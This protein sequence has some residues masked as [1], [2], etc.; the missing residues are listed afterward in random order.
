M[1][2]RYSPAWS[3]IIHK[4]MYYI[5]FLWSKW[6]L[7]KLQTHIFMMENRIRE[8]PLILQGQISNELLL[9]VFATYSSIASLVN[10]I[11]NVILLPRKTCWV[12]VCVLVPAALCARPGDNSCFTSPTAF[13]LCYGFKKL[14]V[15]YCS[16]NCRQ[17]HDRSEWNQLQWVW[18]TSKEWRK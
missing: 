9:N 6:G 13:P 4:W 16:A 2:Y 11:R 18:H 12:S 5:F 14:R 8:K 15:A 17:K 10:F 7:I 1:L 3:R